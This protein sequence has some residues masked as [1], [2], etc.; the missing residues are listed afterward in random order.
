MKRWQFLSITPVGVAL[1][2]WGSDLLVAQDRYELKA[3]NGISFSEIRGYENWE[4]VAPS[5]RTDKKEIR[6]IL[7]NETIVKTYKAGIPENGKPFTDGSILVK[8]A[9]SERKN[10]DFPAALEPDILQRVEFMMKDSKRFKD[11]GGWGYARFL[12]DVKTDTFKPYGKDPAFEQEC[13]QC[14]TIVKGRDF[15]FTRY[16]QK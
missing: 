11:T 15:V 12:Y 3:P 6:Y 5:Y 10:P 1:L 9:Y 16:F 2:F 7:G 14:H 13:H 4:V 8:I